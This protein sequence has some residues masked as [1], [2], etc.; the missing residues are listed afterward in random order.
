MGPW[1]REAVFYEVPVKSFYDSNGD[2]VGDLRGLTQKLDYLQHLEVD[3]L[4]LLPIYPSPRR[5]DGYDISDF[6]GV[7]PEYGS[8]RDFEDFVAE[9]HQRKLRVILDL[10][11]NHTSDQHPWFQSARQPG[12]P[13]RDWYVWSSDDSRYK[14]AR[15]IFTDSEKSNWTWDTAAQAYYW[16][17]FFSHQPDLNYDNPEVRR[18]MIDVARAWLDRG[19]DGLRVDAAPY[20]FE[21]EGTDCEN[22]P[23]T[24]AFLRELRACLDKEYDDRILLAEANQLP[25]QVRPYFGDGDECH[26]AFHFPL[27]PR[28]FIA[29]RKEDRAPIVDVLLSTPE[30]PAGCQWALFLRNHDEL[31]LEMV[32]P[33]EREYLLQE[34]AHHPRMRLNVGIRRRM[35]PLMDFGRRQLELLASLILSMPGTPVLY[36]GDEL[37]M[38]DNIY[39]GDR[40]G[41]RT[42]M[43]WSPDRN[44]GFSRADPEQ[45]YTQPVIN[46]TCSY[47]A[48]NVEAQERTPTSLLHWMKRVLDLRRQHRGVFGAGSM[49]LLEPANPKCLA[50]LREGD[51]QVVLVVDNL[52][53]FAQ[54]VELDL[55]K[56]RGWT[57]VDMFGHARFHPIADPPYVLTL[58]PHGFYWLKLER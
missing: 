42:P 14:D 3:C 27:M 15:V 37:G 51:G 13:K 17:R 35:A 18:E 9:A 52:S 8:V 30:I 45:L 23:E 20:L 49:T 10:V 7:A 1:Y 39:L 21:R 12:S 2:G 6:Y 58:G 36:Y 29:I 5:D 32:T 11:L 56:F 46:P 57:P 26:M 44:A 38:G 50:F 48:I 33:E 22:L 19:V 43:Q 28:I 55:A 47:Q 41:V 34:Y 24:H 25:R 4:W 16:H 40:D 31:T 53:R 54:S